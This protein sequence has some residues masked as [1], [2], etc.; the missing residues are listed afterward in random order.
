MFILPATVTMLQLLVMPMA[1]RL[2]CTH[3][4]CL[5]SLANGYSKSHSGMIFEN[6]QFYAN[7]PTT[8][9]P[10]FYCRCAEVYNKTR[11]LLYLSFIA[12]VTCRSPKSCRNL[13]PNVTSWFLF[14]LLFFIILFSF[15]TCSKLSWS[16][17]FLRILN[18]FVYFTN[19][20]KATG[21]SYWY[22]VKTVHTSI[23]FIEHNKYYDT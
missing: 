5:Q 7:E 13:N 19:F 14:S 21:Y 20:T 16:P 2:Q 8:V 22:P 3:S 6:A 9:E 1:H 11:F 10:Q 15:P 18:I 23:H 4:L 17:A 12:H